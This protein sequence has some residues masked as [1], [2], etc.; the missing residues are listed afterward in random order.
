M[1][2]Q[3]MK[4]SFQNKLPH[5]RKRNVQEM[6]RKKEKIQKIQEIELWTDQRCGFSFSFTNK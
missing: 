3:A 1:T 5:A 6:T 2:K 4:D